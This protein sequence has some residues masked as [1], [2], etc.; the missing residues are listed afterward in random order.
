MQKAPNT[1]ILQKYKFTLKGMLKFETISF[2]GRYFFSHISS[3]TPKFHALAS[4][5]KNYLNLGCGSQFRQAMGGGTII[6]ADF[7]SHLKPYKTYSTPMP[8]WQLDLRYPLQC[9]HNIFDGVF[10]EHTLEHLYIDDAIALLRD[11]FRILKPNGTIRLSV[12]DLEL[13]IQQYLNAKK[14]D[15][16]QQALA[17]EYIRKLTQEYLHIKCMGL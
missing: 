1:P 14:Q 9:P 8:Q 7:F 5:E 17:S 13:H 12:P 11:I 3:R 4:K 6:N 16:H 15:S 10:S 2:L